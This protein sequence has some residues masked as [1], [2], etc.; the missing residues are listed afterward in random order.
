VFT[1][2][3]AWQLLY[4]FNCSEFGA[5]ARAEVAEGD[6]VRPGKVLVNTRT[7]RTEGSIRVNGDAG[8]HYLQVN[9]PCSWVVKVVDRA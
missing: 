1:T 4:S 2:T 5:P 7:L 9:S 3:A 8:S 6:R